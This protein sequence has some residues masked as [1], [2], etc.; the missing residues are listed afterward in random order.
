MIWASF[1][2]AE[3]HWFEPSSSHDNGDK[4]FR[5]LRGFTFLGMVQQWY[6]ILK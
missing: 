6:N 4:P 1:L 3:G 5:K 2:Q